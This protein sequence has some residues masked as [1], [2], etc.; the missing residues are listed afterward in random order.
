MY[1]TIVVEAKWHITECVF[2]KFG[3]KSSHE[4]SQ[5]K[6]TMTYAGNCELIAKQRWFHRQS[7]SG[8]TIF[9]SSPKGYFSHQNFLVEEEDTGAPNKGE[10]LGCSR[11][12]YGAD[13]FSSSARKRQSECPQTKDILYSF[14]P[15]SLSVYK[16]EFDNLQPCMFEK[17][18]N[19]FRIFKARLYRTV[20]LQVLDVKKC[21]FFVI[22]SISATFITALDG[23]AF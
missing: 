5:Q 15:S 7:P 18:A 3:N 8:Q 12:T 17:V 9:V 6:C 1:S 23:I 11:K 22:A 13:I 4:K 21:G 20:C 14:F 19:R 2:F 10:R 16:I